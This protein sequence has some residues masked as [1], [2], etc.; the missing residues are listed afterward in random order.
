MPKDPNTI[1]ETAQIDTEDWEIA[2]KPY[3][4]APEAALTLA[5]NLMIMKSYLVDEPVDI[6]SVTES[7]DVAIKVLFPFTLFHKVSYVLFRRVAEGKMDL[8]MEEALKKLGIR[9]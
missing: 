4:E 2:F 5:C 3:G 9:F 7:I 8:E 6:E 1:L